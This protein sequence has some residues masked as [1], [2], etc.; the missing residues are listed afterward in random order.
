MHTLAAAYFAEVEELKRGM[1]TIMLLHAC[2]KRLIL[3]MLNS[4]CVCL[5]GIHTLA[6]VEAGTQRGMQTMS[7][8]MKWSL[9]ATRPM[10]R[11]FT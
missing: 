7:C 4:A 11:Q 5:L 3:I 1:H 8:G 6:V 10:R 2:Y 9:R